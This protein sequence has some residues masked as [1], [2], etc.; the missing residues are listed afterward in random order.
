MSFRWFVYYCALGGGCAAYLGWL[1]G[2]LVGLESSLGLAVVRGLFVGMMIALGLSLLDA[3]WNGFRS[4]SGTLALVLQSVIA[5]LLG[6][7][8]GCLGGLIGQSLYGR[9]QLSIYLLLGWTVTGLLVGGSIGVFDLISGVLH[10][11]DTRG[12]LRK[13]IHGLLGG[14]IGGLLG[15]TFFIVLRSIWETI[16]KNHQGDYW[17]PGATGFIVLG[18]CIGLMVSLAQVLLTEAWIKIEAGFRHGRELL[19]SRPV[20]VIGR[21][22]ACDIGLFG[23][24]QIEKVHCNITRRG[25]DYVLTDE[26]TATGTYVND[27]RVNEPRKLR[28]GDLIRLGRNLLRFGQRAKRQ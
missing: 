24:D 20:V 15:G 26:G 14:S 11:E 2:R 28:S 13:I 17:S 8:S 1:L 18:M 12:T 9:S 3:L 25:N 16:L 21:A 22:E 7:V 6:C 27:E 19:L 10:R 4:S 5:P 23:D